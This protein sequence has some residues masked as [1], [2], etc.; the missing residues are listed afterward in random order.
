M[1]TLAFCFG[2]TDLPLTVHTDNKIQLSSVIYQQLWLLQK[3][4]R[5]VEFVID[6]T[7][8]TL[9]KSSIISEEIF[10][11]TFSLYLSSKNIC[12]NN[13]HPLI[14]TIIIA[15]CGGI[16]FKNE[17]N[18]FMID[19]STRQMYRECSVLIPI[20]EYLD[21]E[22]EPHSIKIQTCIQ[23]YEYI[24]QQSSLSNCSNDIIDSFIALI[25]L[26]GVHKLIIYQKYLALPFALDKLKRTWFDLKTSR[27]ECVSNDNEWMEL[28]LIKSQI[29]SLIH[30]EQ[31]MLFSTACASA[32]K[33]LAFWK[34]SIWFSR[35]YFDMIKIIYSQQMSNEKLRFLVD[36]L[37]E[38]LQELYYHAMITLTNDTNTYL[39]ILLLSE[40]LT[41]LKQSDENH[42][43]ALI[44]LYPLFKEYKLENYA[45]I[46]FTENYLN[47][48]T[49]LYNKYPRFIQTIFDLFLNDQSNSFITRIHHEH[50]RIQEAM[51]IDQ[52]DIKDIRL[53]AASI[54]FVR[55]LNHSHDCDNKNSIIINSTDREQ[56]YSAIINISNPILRISALSI[57]MKDP[58]IFDEE[59]IDQLQND[60]LIELIS[61]ISENSL[62]IGSI[63]FI[64]CYK[65]LHHLSSQQLSYIIAE[66]FH[67]SINK[68]DANTESVFI[69]LKQL[70]NSHL[71]HCL[72]EFIEQNSNFS[73][74][75]TIFFRYITNRTSFDSSN[76]VL[77]SLMHLL[78][79]I[80][81][82]Q[83]LRIN[84]HENIS[85]MK[86]LEQLW[87]IKKVMTNK[88]AIWITNNLQI[89]NREDQNIIIENL[90]ECLTIERK[91][92]AEID[93]WLNYRTDEILKFFSYYAALQLFLNGSNNL[94]FIEIINEMFVID[95][96]FRLKLILE[97]FIDSPSPDLNILRQIFVLLNK[98]LIKFSIS[99]DSIKMFELFLDLEFERI[100]LK[101]SSNSFLSI[102]GSYS[103]GFQ[104][105]LVK[106]FQLYLNFSE[107]LAQDQYLAVIIKWMNKNMTL[108]N[109]NDD[110]KSEFSIKLFKF[111]F[112]FPKK[113]Q[114]PLVLQVIFEALSSIFNGHCRIN[115]SFFQ[116]DIAVC[117]EEIIYS[118]D[119]YSEDTLAAFLVT[120][121]HYLLKFH[122]HI[123]DDLKE[124]LCILSQTLIS[125]VI[126]I[127][128][129]FCLI[130]ISYSSKITSTT[131]SNWFRDQSNITAEK[132]Y[133]ILLQQTLYSL[134][135]PIYGH[136]VNEIIDQLETHST[137]FLDLFVID[138]YNHLRKMCE[139]DDHSVFTP[140]YIAIAG[141]IHSRKWDE[142][143]HAIQRSSFG[144]EK[145]K[146]KL[147][148]C[149]KKHPQSCIVY[150]DLYARFGVVTDEFVE[151]CAEHKRN[152][153]C[154]FNPKSGMEYL[155]EVSDRDVTDNLFRELNLKTNG[156]KFPS[157][158]WIIEYL[159]KNNVISLLEMHSRVQLLNN[160]WSRDDTA[161]LTDEQ[162]VFKLLLENSC[163]K[164][165]GLFNVKKISFN[166]N[167]IDEKFDEIIDMIDQ[168]FILCMRRNQFY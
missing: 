149:C 18:L 139:D 86:E 37:P 162:Y 98:N 100:T 13:I 116:N 17:N 118:R 137:Q 29:E 19:F 131:I 20:I 152:Y 1:H 99:I 51:Y 112:A 107:N 140:K 150:I 135:E 5:S 89:L 28:S 79:L 15:L 88:I 7:L 54:S 6:R 32:W 38:S 49:F 2:H 52:T 27:E 154:D 43:L 53:F 144:E 124:Q 106:H 110:V 151:M 122:K 24:I 58:L 133:K 165:N 76:T 71:S 23:N 35:D 166:T 136:L 66:K 158:L 59:Q 47:S 148:F 128:A 31:S 21:N 75:S 3:I 95:H 91:A 70:K 25:C 145:F 56:I 39:L 143:R 159:V 33:K 130:F 40:C 62:L 114:F 138:L 72:S 73:D 34:L 74:N 157:Y 94:D 109:A 120:Y 83:I 113:E 96:K 63:L 10:N 65:I 46:I 90:S 102:I 161:D 69:A 123:S 64:R 160:I 111:I 16:V 101:T 142:F 146:R 26:Q 55:L 156:N 14:V 9:I 82:S 85:P 125:D 105:Y 42:Y 121:G 92:L 129:N 11:K 61:L 117:L 80:F 141:E 30:N 8:Q 77:L 41:N 97:N 164:G 104:S 119:K 60:I 153:M 126:S 78:E 12:I 115:D 81:D 57:I 50:E 44:L 36:F 4:N 108:F 84:P 132:R 167:D 147:Y 168:K 45:S 93:K 87:T 155:K 134:G 127:R 103:R 22:N 48:T 68:Q 67:N 163:Y